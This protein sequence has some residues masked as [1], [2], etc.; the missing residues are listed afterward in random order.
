MLSARYVYVL[1]CGPLQTTT[2]MKSSS[3]WIMDFELLLTTVKNPKGTKEEKDNTF[4]CSDVP[5]G[6]G[7]Q[8]PSEIPKF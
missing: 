6:G 8:P 2:A 3:Y 4:Q 1:V 7:V 5:R